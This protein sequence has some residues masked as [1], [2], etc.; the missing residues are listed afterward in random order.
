MNQSTSFLIE[1]FPRNASLPSGTLTTLTP[2]LFYPTYPLNYHP[3][4]AFLMPSAFTHN[5]TVIMPRFLKDEFYTKKNKQICILIHRTKVHICSQWKLTLDQY[6]MGY[7]II[8]VR[9]LEKFVLT[10]AFCDRNLS[11]IFGSIGCV[12]EGWF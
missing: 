4:V 8:T 5:L 11:S 7:Q 6:L 1:S 12:I 2:T 3:R 10:I 9:S